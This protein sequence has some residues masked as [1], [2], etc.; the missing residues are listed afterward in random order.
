MGYMAQRFN[1]A[2]IPSRVVGGDTSAEERDAALRELKDGTI[3]ALF[4]VDI[5]NKGVDVPQIDTV[6]MLRPTE[7][8]TI[9]LQQLGR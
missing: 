2:G 7:S 9:F 3:N 4:A 6:L 1:D 8:P 5:V